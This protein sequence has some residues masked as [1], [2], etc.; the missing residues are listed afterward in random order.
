MYLVHE[1]LLGNLYLILKEGKLKSHYLSGRIN[2]GYGVYSE[3][4][5]FVYFFLERKL[6]IDST[7]GTCKLYFNTELLYNRDFY[8]ST[9]QSSSPDNTGKWENGK[10]VMM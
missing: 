9:L 3:P 6:F 1:T 4:N 10:M 7:F 8:L 5:K 2:N